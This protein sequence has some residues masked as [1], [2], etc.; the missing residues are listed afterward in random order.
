MTSRYLGWSRHSPPRIGDIVYPWG[1][2]TPAEISKIDRRVPERPVYEVVYLRDD[3]AII[4]W[5]MKIVI[6]P[7]G[8]RV[9]IAEEDLSGHPQR[10]SW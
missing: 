8:T 6:F 9:K 7:S 4:H 1:N 2:A 5:W 10:K 3:I